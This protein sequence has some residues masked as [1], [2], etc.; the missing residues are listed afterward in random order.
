M[1][2]GMRHERGSIDV[3]KLRSYSHGEKHRS[4]VKSAIIGAF[5]LGVAKLHAIQPESWLV[6]AESAPV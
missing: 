6:F 2:C 1:A 4:T 3:S 5:E